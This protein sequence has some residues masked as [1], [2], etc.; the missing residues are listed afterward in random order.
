MIEF[1]LS[2]LTTLLHCYTYTFVD[3]QS[4]SFKQLRHRSHLKNYLSY[5]LILRPLIKP[6]NGGRQAAESYYVTYFWLMA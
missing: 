6:R 4:E 3:Y 2:I 5:V 1:L